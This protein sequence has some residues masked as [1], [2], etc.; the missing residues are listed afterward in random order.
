M[1]ALRGGTLPIRL[2]GLHVATHTTSPL[3]DGQYVFEAAAVDAAGNKDGLAGVSDLRGRHRRAE[4]ESRRRSGRH[5]NPGCDLRVLGERAGDLRVPARPGRLGQMRFAP[6]V[7][8]DLALGPHRF[9]VRAAD[10]GR[11]RG[12]ESAARTWQVLKAGGAVPGVE[13]QAVAL[14][15]AIAGMRRTLSHTSLRRLYRKR[16]VTLRGFGTLTAGE[17]ECRVTT[18]IRLRSGRYRRPCPPPR[19]ALRSGRRHYSV[20]AE[21]TKQRQATGSPAQAIGD[22][23]E[24]HIHG[25]RGTVSVGTDGRHHDAVAAGVARTARRRA[26]AAR[27]PWRPRRVCASGMAGSHPV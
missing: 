9:E 6:V 22:H 1:P 18:R 25:S 7:L 23:T 12:G 26:R 10:R 19:A 14:A 16:S 5:P 8:E 21:L 20:A 15:G 11:E 27:R 24:A 13:Q 2:R 3:E 17:L 4:Y